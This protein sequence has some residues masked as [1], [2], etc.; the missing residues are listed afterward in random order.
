MKDE[1][2]LKWLVENR[3]LVH[4]AGL[5]TDDEHYFVV[6]RDGTTS[7]RRATFRA[8]IDAAKGVK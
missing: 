3:A 2:R 6:Y 1:I 8:A 5:N 4:T 7:D